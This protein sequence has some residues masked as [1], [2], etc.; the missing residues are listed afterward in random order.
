M[1]VDQ[2][3]RMNGANFILIFQ[4]IPAHMKP[5]R[6]AFGDITENVVRHKYERAKM[7]TQLMLDEEKVPKTQN[8]CKCAYAWALSRLL[9]KPLL[10]IQRRSLR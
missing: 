7:Q 2:I 9:L 3:L 5:C 10:D 4:V 6:F 1:F 8:H